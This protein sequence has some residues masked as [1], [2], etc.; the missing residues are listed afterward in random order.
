MRSDRQSTFSAV[1]LTAGVALSLAF[2]AQ[3]VVLAALRARY[4][5][6]LEWM[7]GSMAD[8][9]QRV[10]DG[11]RL[12]VPPTLEFAP[13]LYTPLFYY[14]SAA[15]AL[16][17]GP[18]LFPLRLVSIAA[19]LVVFGL[20]HAFVRRGTSSH[21]LGIVA[22]GLFAATYRLGGAWFDLARVDS[23]FLALL[24]GAFYVLHG[25]PGV[26]RALVAGLLLVLAF[27][28]KQVALTMCL[29]VLAWAVLREWRTGLV[30]A[31]TTLGG[32]A[33]SVTVLNALHDGWYV[34]YCFTVPS[35]HAMERQ[36]L[37]RFWTYDLWTFVWPMTAASAWW[38]ARLVGRER[39]G[40]DAM[41]HAAATVGIVA[42]AWMGRL[43]SGGWEN[44]VIPA[45]ALLTILFAF[46]MRDL[47]VAAWRPAL[48]G[49]ALAGALVVV[50]F[51]LLAYDAR[52]QLPSQDDLRAGQALVDFLERTPGEVWLF[53]HGYLPSL[54]G[55]DPHAPAAAL[56][57]VLRAD[58]GGVG[59]ALRHEIDTA[60]RD[61]RF[62]AIIIDSHREFPGDLWTRYWEEGSLFQ[63]SEGFWPVTGFRKRPEFVFRRY[64]P[65]PVENVAEGRASRPA[66]D[67]GARAPAQ[68][69]QQD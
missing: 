45:Y 46:G 49:A 36:F 13:Y 41:F 31:A 28:T 66:Q 17:T 69:D 44:V 52:A 20:L 40:S 6:E 9:V 23:L 15:V 57:D 19:T 37:V 51:R 42:G 34:F 53:D 25:G 14:V 7:E 10:L 65:W 5:F 27:Q 29:P 21:A 22:M 47:L 59:D 61:G 11:R 67:G 32:I 33:A 16:V 2:L 26:V 54:A 35:R 8:H 64:D 48:A 58:T 1:V 60:V 12:Y 50:Q 18:G 38:L 4:P 63:T 56:W 68:V 24:L 39:P 55:R 62:A 30:A 3:F 43:H